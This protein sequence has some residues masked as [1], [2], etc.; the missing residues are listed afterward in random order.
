MKSTLP[1]CVLLVSTFSLSALAIEPPLIVKPSEPIEANLLQRATDGVVDPM[2]VEVSEQARAQITSIH[3][4]GGTVIPLSEL[5]AQVKPLLHQTYS[6]ELVSAAVARITQRYQDAGYILCYATVTNSGFKD[7]KLTITLVEGYVL[8]SEIVIAQSD[9]KQKVANILAPVLAQKPLT[10]AVL[11]R[12]IILVKQ[13]PGYQF[14]ILL[15]KPK[16]LSGATSIRVEVK[17]RRAIEPMFSFSK[18]RLSDENASLALKLNSIDARFSEIKVTGLAPIKDRSERYFALSVANDWSANGLKG[19]LQT[20]FYQ[21]K[22][23]NNFVFNGFDIDYSQDIQRTTF[24]YE[25]SYPWLLANRQRLMVNAAV[26]HSRERNAFILYN[27]GSELQ[28]LSG[29]V[30]YSLLSVKLDY[31]KLIDDFVW[32]SSVEFAHNIDLGED[33][34]AYRSYYDQDFTFY[35][36][37]SLF[38]YSF[39]DGWRIDLGLNGVYSQDRIVANERVTYGG[40]FYASGYPEGQAEGDRGYGA[41]LQLQKIVNMNRFH[42]TPYVLLDIA[43]TEFVATDFQ[44]NLASLAV[45]IELGE[46]DDYSMT[47]EYAK[48]LDDDNFITQD[49]SAIYNLRFAWNI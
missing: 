26:R 4:A 29:D 19:R 35:S 15:P 34:A 6:T 16:T 49:K 25:L 42:V 12:A 38:R 13:L 39:L 46:A 2:D 30:D 9:I 47:L 22:S 44:H 20:D 11:E 37:N 36:V 28:R 27:Q 21:D 40:Q 43:H 33:S 10:Q 3:F 18:Q 8:Q 32:V 14:N 45:G 31:A 23:A 7:G 48:P 1:L 41:K 5:A 24:Q 17:K